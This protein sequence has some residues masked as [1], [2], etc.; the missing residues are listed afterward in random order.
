MKNKVIIITGG[1][2][3]IGQS[4][5][6]TLKKAG[7]SVVVSARSEADLQATAKLLADVPEGKFLTVKSDVTKDADLD[8][9]LQATK[10]EFGAVYGLICAAG[11]YGAIGPFAENNFSEWEQA[12]QINLIG[13]A[14]TIHRTLPYMTDPSGGRILLFSGGGQG[15]MANFSSYVT[16]KGG[17]WRFTETLG[18]ELA[19]KKI[20]VNSIAP[21]AVNTKLLQDLIS[22]G[23]DKVGKEFYEK[24]MQQKDNGGQS[25]EKAANLCLYLLSE[26]SAG[27]Y[28]KTLSAIWDPYTEFKDL[29]KLSKSDIYTVRRI[30]DEQGNTRSK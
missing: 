25:P 26:K 15:A 29:E 23:P 2:R 21:G 22:A 16:G 5:A 9:L 20:Y 6:L 4:I 28:G 30:V 19:S 24:S 18:A 11:V 7:A 27:L 17:I 10:K 3:G 12:I 8:R 1:G 14:R 13:T